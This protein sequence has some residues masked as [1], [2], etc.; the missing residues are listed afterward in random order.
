MVRQYSYEIHVID[1]LQHKIKP[2]CICI[3]VLFY[4]TKKE[5]YLFILSL[6]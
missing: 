1:D 3:R 5:H 2:G 4:V 6:R